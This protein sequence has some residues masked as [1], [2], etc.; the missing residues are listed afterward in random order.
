MSL[1]L[2]GS[3]SMPQQLPITTTTT[4]DGNE[5]TTTSTTNTTT[6]TTANTITTDKQ[7]QQQEKCENSGGGG[8][9]GDGGGGGGGVEVEEPSIPV[10]VA[11]LHSL[12]EA[13]CLV[14]MVNMLQSDYSLMVS[15]PNLT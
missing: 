9:G 13:G 2:T 8:G 1:C 12:V 11:V 5:D 6:N 7:Q 14:P 15:K 4:T 3:P 10:G